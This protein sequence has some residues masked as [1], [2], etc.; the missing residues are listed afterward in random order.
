MSH[1]EQPWTAEH[2]RRFQEHYKTMR[3]YVRREVTHLNIERTLKDYLSE[4]RQ[5]VDLGGGEGED[6]R[7]LA[8]KGHEVVLADTNSEAIAKAMALG[9]EL[10]EIVLGTAGDVIEEF[11]PGSFD[12]VVSH[13]TLLYSDDPTRDL[14]QM[15]ALLQPGGYLSLLTAGKF[16]KVRRFERNGQSAALTKLLATGKYVNNLGLEASAYLPQEVDGLLAANG[17]KTEDWFGVRI[18][19]DEDDR[20]VDEV[21][22]L[23]KN[24]ILRHEVLASADPTIRP[25][26]QLLLFIARKNT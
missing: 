25:A 4:P 16:G 12:M 15:G 19:S 17:F 8:A 24:R 13:G 3:G 22:A 21:P 10:E 23:H 26:G 7:W 14:S 9:A 5:I 11:G 6:A 2:S 18:F 20:L 1:P